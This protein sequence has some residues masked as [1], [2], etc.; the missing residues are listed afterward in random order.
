MLHKQCHASLSR[1]ADDY[2]GRMAENRK[3]ALS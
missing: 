3:E 1:L 2:H